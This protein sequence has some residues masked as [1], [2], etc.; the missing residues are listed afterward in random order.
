MDLDSFFE[1]DS[2]IEDVLELSTKISLMSTLELFESSS[3]I[4]RIRF[5]VIV[6]LV[7]VSSKTDLNKFLF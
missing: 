5:F 3:L 4:S 2:G 1:G 7:R 6:F